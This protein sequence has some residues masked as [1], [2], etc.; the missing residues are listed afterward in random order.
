MSQENVEIVNAALRALGGL[1]R[2]QATILFAPEAEWHNTPEF[3]GPSVCVGPDQ[4]VDFW[5][6][7]V[8][9]FGGGGN[10]IEQITDIDGRVVVG[11]R[12]WGSGRLSGAPVDVQYAAIFDL[13][14]QRITRVRVH[15]DYRTALEAAG[16]SSRSYSR[17]QGPDSSAPESG[18]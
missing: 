10:E 5:A 8:E 2:G 18:A 4:I 13:V 7:M 6:G 17:P 1:D 15:G 3:P 14:D 12:S 16:P 11:I 9:G